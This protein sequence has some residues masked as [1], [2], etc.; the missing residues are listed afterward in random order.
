MKKYLILSF[1]I[2][3]LFCASS[4]YAQYINGK[5]VDIF[6]DKVTV[7]LEGGNPFKP[8]DKFDM[9]Y[10]AGFLEMMIGQYKVETIKDLVVIAKTVS[11]NMPPSKGMKVKVHPGELAPVVVPG[12]ENSPKV[13][14]GEEAGGE[15]GWFGLGDEVDENAEIS[16]EVIEVMGNDVRIKLTSSGTPRV[17]WNAE[18]LFVTSQGNEIPAGTWIVTS[19]SGREVIAEDK[20]GN[21]PPRVGLKAKIRKGSSKKPMK[22]VKQDVSPGPG[23]AGKVEDLFAGDGGDGIFKGVP[24][25]EIPFPEGGDIF[26]DFFPDTANQIPPEFKDSKPGPPPGKDDFLDNF[27][28]RPAGPGEKGGG[29][30]PPLPE[31]FVEL[32]WED[33]I[34]DLKRKYPPKDSAQVLNEVLGGKARAGLPVRWWLGVEIEK[35]RSPMGSRY[36]ALVGVRICSVMKGSPA[37]KGGLQAGD[38]VYKVDGV[39]VNTAGEFVTLIQ[40]NGRGRPTFELD[41]NYKLKTITVQMHKI[42]K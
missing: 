28:K 26:G 24:D 25:E 20:D 35:N 40:R 23:G 42:G 2:V 39:E 41:R 37:K 5:V 16:G 11:Q 8:G 17:G 34:E 32:T 21:A 6:D 4:A 14:H 38:L 29:L 1:A 13:E 22:Y 10:I 15:S 33:Y 36:A 30:F 7:L 18:L 31:G 12:G 9:I 27:F 19:I 3:C